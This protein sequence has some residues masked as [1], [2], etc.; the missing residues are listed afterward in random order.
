MSCKKNDSTSSCF[1]CFDDESSYQD[2]VQ[3]I[4]T[5]TATVSEVSFPVDDH[6]S[7]T[8][9]EMISFPN[10]SQSSSA[11]LIEVPGLFVDD[12]KEASA[13]FLLPDSG[14]EPSSQDPVESSQTS[15]ENLI[16]VPGL[17]PESSQLFSL[18]DSCNDPSFQ[19]PVESPPTSNENLIE[20]P[21]LLVDDRESSQSNEPSSQDPTESSQ[22]SHK[23]LVEVPGFLSPNPTAATKEFQSQVSDFE[24]EHL[25][26]GPKPSDFKVSDSVIASVNQSTGHKIVNAVNLKLGSGWILK[27]NEFC[28]SC[29]AP[30]M[31]QHSLSGSPDIISDSSSCVLCNEVLNCNVVPG[32]GFNQIDE[33]AIPVSVKTCKVSVG[34]TIVNEVGNLMAKGWVVKEND[35]CESCGLPKMSLKEGAALCILCDEFFIQLSKLTNP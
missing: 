16:E 35:I 28:D 13:M 3:S 5:T 8:R 17:S 32:Q 34:S 29:G 24:S 7:N 11:N 2:S 12:S 21:V 31:V 22:V 14:Y 4:R 30:I 15:S 20:V 23:N 25:K 10:S 18:P 6:F 33:V 27:E 9:S 19:D 1:F 26:A